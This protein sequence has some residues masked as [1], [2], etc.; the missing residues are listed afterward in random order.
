MCNRDI[1][2]PRHFHSGI[3]PKNDYPYIVLLLWQTEDIS[4]H[5]IEPVR[6]LDIGDTAL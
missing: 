1:I 2:S 6:E 4:P 3:S 5:A